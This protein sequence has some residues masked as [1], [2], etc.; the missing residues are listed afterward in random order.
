MTRDFIIGLY[1]SLLFPD[2]VTGNYNSRSLLSGQFYKT[3]YYYYLLLYI[4]ILI[5]GPLSN[6]AMGMA[7]TVTS[8]LSSVSS[9]LLLLC[10]I[11]VLV[12]VVL[13][14]GQTLHHACAQGAAVYVHVGTV[15][16]GNRRI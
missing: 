5:R 4:F 12:Y 8:S 3:D 1:I 15:I 6:R 16:P 9:L 14:V 7:D 11:A 2:L 10:F 13:H